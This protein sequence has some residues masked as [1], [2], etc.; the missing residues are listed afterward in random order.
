[1]IRKAVILNLISI[2]FLFFSVVSTNAMTVRDETIKDAVY[3]KVNQNLANSNLDKY[4][5]SIGALPFSQ[6][7][8]PDGKLEIMVDD[9]GTKN[10]TTRNIVRASFYVDGQYIKSVGIPVLIKAYKNVYAANGYIEKGKMITSKDVKLKL[11]NISNNTSHFLNEKDFERGVEALK[12]FNEDEI[13]SERFVRSVPDI[14]KNSVVKV[15]INSKNTIYITTD[16]IAL[17]DGKIGDTI[18]VQNKQLKKIYTGKIIDEN[19]V[20]VKM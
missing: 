3:E 11:I 10:F 19:K 15:I 18:N 8:F 4:E 7:N 16:A 1:M 20:L 17:A 13:I 6:L 14:Q 2:M 5:L 9:I 12:P